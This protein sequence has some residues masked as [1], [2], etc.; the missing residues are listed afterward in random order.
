MS[1]IPPFA[2]NAKDGA[3][4]D[5]SQG[6]PRPTMWL[7]PEFASYQKAARV[8]VGEWDLVADRTS[9]TPTVPSPAQR[10]VSSAP[11]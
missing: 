8:V 1:R 7:N 5:L 10:E 6:L 2:K 9:G 3:P 4:G 11:G